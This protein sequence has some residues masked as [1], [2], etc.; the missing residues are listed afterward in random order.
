MPLTVPSDGTVRVQC[1]SHG[2]NLQVA[3]ATEGRTGASLFL[4]AF[5]L[6][7]RCRESPGRHA[8]T[9][10]PGQKQQQLGGRAASPGASAPELHVQRCNGTSTFFTSNFFPEVSSTTTG[11]LVLKPMAA[12]CWQQAPAAAAFGAEAGAGA[13]G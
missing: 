6:F 7:L 2:Q 5:Q 10:C 12:S 1:A 3:A 8:C 4:L 9:V 11:R 13:G